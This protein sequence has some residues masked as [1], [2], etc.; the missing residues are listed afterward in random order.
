MFVTCPECGGNPVGYS[1]DCFG[2]ET[3]T[4]CSCETGEI[5]IDDPIELEEVA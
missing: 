1:V 3:W 5:E 4:E 2:N